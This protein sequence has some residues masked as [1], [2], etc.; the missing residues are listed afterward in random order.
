MHRL[1][2]VFLL[3]PLSAWAQI[4]QPGWSFNQHFQGGSNASGTILKSD[5]TVAFALDPYLNLYGGLPIYFT[6]PDVVVAPGG[7]PQFLTGVGNIYLG[8]QTPINSEVANYTSD[9][10]LMFPTGSKDRGLNTGR[11]SFDWN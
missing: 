8:I 11:L 7:E 3:C 10:V 4:D 1:A 5:T 6:R 9:A 2:L